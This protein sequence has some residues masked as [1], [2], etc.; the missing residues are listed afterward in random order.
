MALCPW[1]SRWA[2]GRGCSPFCHHLRE[3]TLGVAP[4][5]GR[6]PIG[7]LPLFWLH[8]LWAASTLAR[9]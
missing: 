5:G 1:A 4:F 8:L 6:H 2:G 7:L 3:V 9:S